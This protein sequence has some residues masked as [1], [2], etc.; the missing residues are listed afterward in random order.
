MVKELIMNKPYSL[1]DLKKYSD[2]RGDLTKIFDSKEKS[3]P[4]DFKV[5]EIIL[6]ENK[7]KGTIRGIHFQFPF[8]NQ[9]K[10]VKCLGGAAFVVF[11]DLRKKSN[12]YSKIYNL[13][14]TKKHNHVIFVPPGVALGYQTLK[15]NTNIIYLIGSNYDQEKDF[16]INPF[17]NALNIKWPLKT[18][19]VSQRDRESMTLDFYE[20]MF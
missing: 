13:G 6:T 18:S 19:I 5:E 12:S 3:L 20:K 1:I 16:A 8:E 4:I 7:K 10:I 9:Y 2:F 14:L 17:D 11:L 15:R